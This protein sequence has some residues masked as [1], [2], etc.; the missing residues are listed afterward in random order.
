MAADA[1]KVT[2]I[3]GH[4]EEPWRRRAMD[5]GATGFLQ[6]PIEAKTPSQPA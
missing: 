1:P 6:K 5:A 3:T 2:L 4:L